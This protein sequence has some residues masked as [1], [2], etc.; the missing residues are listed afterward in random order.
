VKKEASSRITMAKRISSTAIGVFVISSVAILLTTIMIVGSGKL[1]KHPLLLVCMF[2]GDLN[3]LNVGAPVKFS[4]IQI[5]SV[6]D[7]KIALSPEEGSLKQNAARL[8][9]LPVIVEIDRSKLVKRGGKGLAL[10]DEG[11]DQMVK[12]GLRAKLNTESILTGLLYVDLDLFPDTPV[13]FELQ[14]GGRYREIPTI[15]T[16][17]ESVQKQATQALAK[18]QQIDFKAL[19]ASI[20]EAASS[21]RI[22]ADSP[23]TRATLEAL[24]GTTADLNQ[25]V[26]AMR[27]TLENVNN[28]IDPIVANLQK[29]SAEINATLRQTQA[30]LIAVEGVL[31]PDSPVMAR[32]SETLDQLDDTSRSLGSFTDYLQQNPSA[33]VRGKYIPAKD[34]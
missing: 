1:F 12:L 7:V 2:E 17:L 31:D 32:L 13:N 6:A 23:T 30:T 9:W 20:T 3:G 18:F 21:I 19:A 34:R 22:L 25:T 24:R 26:V 5:G 10:A 16:T 28:H 4:G 14:P 27:R 15:P 33:L 8:D 11:F 29:N